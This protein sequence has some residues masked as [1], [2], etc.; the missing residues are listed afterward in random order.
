MGHRPT[1]P[2]TP[3]PAVAP[4]TRPHQ[5]AGP[6]P[7][8]LL[9]GAARFERMLP[10]PGTPTTPASSDGG[11]GVY[12]EAAWPDD[13]HNAHDR[14]GR[15]PTEMGSV[16]GQ[17]QPPLNGCNMLMGANPVD[18]DADC[19]GRLTVVT[20]AGAGPALA[21]LV[22][23]E[24]R[25]GTWYMEHERNANDPQCDDCASADHAKE[26]AAVEDN[27]DYKERQQ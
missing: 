11:G 21:I 16:G 7:S 3:R 8:S 1:N 19:L 12:G 22:E 2:E 25:C 4:C 10:A 18:R 27:C 24:C 20:R 15:R 5:I 6:V 23:V 14:G 9:S 17:G 26:Q 13:T